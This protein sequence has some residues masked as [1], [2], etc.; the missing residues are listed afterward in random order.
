[1]ST[2]V[3]G[4]GAMFTLFTYVV[5]MLET[6]TGASPAFVTIALVIIGVGFTIGNGLGGKLADWSLDGSLK[7]FLGAIVVMML[8]LPF[9]LTSYAGAAIG[10]LL[11]GVAT[12]AVVPPVQIRVMQAAS[13]APGLASSVNIG[14]FN[15]G[16]ALGAAVG[17]VVISSGM[18]LPV[19]SYAG[20]ALAALGLVV[21]FIASRT[22]VLVSQPAE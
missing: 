13:E 6:M 19:V 1:M 10:L 7:L 5:P 4:A 2:T 20:A 21:V 15:L 18:D 17:G 16:N 3:L 9:L 11:W 12:F 22:P 8:A 14:A